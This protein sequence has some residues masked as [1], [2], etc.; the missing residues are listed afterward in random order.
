MCWGA[1]ACGWNKLGP[2]G[3]ALGWGEK[4]R[5]MSNVRRQGHRKARAACIHAPCKPEMALRAWYRI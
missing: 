3:R 5:Q 4:E 2:L 1:A